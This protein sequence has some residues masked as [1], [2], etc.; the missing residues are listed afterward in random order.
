MA[1]GKNLV[2]GSAQMLLLRLLA[3]RDMYG[4]QM[5]EELAQRSNDTF[6]LKAGTLYPILH[7]LE[8]DGSIESY[9]QPGGAATAGKPRRYY[10][11]TRAGRGAL[12][13]QQTEWRRV[14]RA[15][16]TAIGYEPKPEDIDI[17]GLDGVTVD[18]IKGLLDV[19]KELWLEDVKGVEELYAQIGDHVPAELHAEAAALRERLSK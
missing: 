16:E 8:A 1:A 17:T 10:R 14:S 19:D 4:Y 9:E 12:E 5:I 18:T 13:A 2:P 11:I 15:V 6:A 7:A 3:E